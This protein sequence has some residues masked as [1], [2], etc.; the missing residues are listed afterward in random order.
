MT[1][2]HQPTLPISI[3]IPTL[4]EEDNI[5][6]LACNLAGVTG[7][8]IIVDGGSQDG[9][10]ELAAQHGFKIL[11]SPPGRGGQLNIGATAA[12]G[13]ILLFL[14]ADTRLP[15]N[16]EK[17][18]PAALS[19]PGCIAGAFRLAIDTPTPAMRFIAFCANLRSAWLEMP[20]GDQ[21]IFIAKESFFKL[22]K[23]VE[24]PIMEDYLFIRK[25]RKSGKIVLLQEHAT[26][27]ARRWRRLGLLRTT[28]INQLVVI[29][30]HLN[31]PVERLARL[32][33]R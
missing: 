9:T 8:I 15:E 7:E 4:N 12:C 29:G 19:S 24:T 22:G 6:A 26:T 3:I 21:A 18:V 11:H 16:F 20:Y 17:S 10:I 5:A 1:S 2:T 13:A 23:F 32:Y 25:A 31:V 27:S 28:L 33:R 14:H 30:Y